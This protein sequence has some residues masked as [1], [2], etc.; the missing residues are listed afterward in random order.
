MV[1]QVLSE[2]V[3]FEQRPDAR[4]R[5]VYSRH[6]R[7][8]VQ[9]PWGRKELGVR[10]LWQGSQGGKGYAKFPNFS[11]STEPF[12]AGNGGGVGVGWVLHSQAS[13]EK[14]DVRDRP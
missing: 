2:K 4:L 7:Q 12:A 11:K 5:E 1:G 9:R 8:P 14:H 13:L 6:R 3:T 10:S